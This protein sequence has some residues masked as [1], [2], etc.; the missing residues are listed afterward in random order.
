MTNIMIIYF[1]SFNFKL[2][3]DLTCIAHLVDLHKQNRTDLRLKNACNTFRKKLWHNFIKKIM[4]QF[5]CDQV[6]MMPQ[7]PMASIPNP[8]A[9]PGTRSA[10]PYTVF[11]LD[12]IRQQ[13]RK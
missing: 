6:D 10:R 12:Q 2:I 11:E 13:M 7:P 5:L 8:G 1:L 3:Y 4:G 9:M